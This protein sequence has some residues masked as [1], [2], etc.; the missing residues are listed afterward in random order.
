MHTGILYYCNIS[1]IWILY[2]IMSGTVMY[3]NVV[4]IPLILQTF[5][6]KPRGMVVD[7]DGDDDD[8]L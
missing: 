7:D 8:E 4:R 3:Q 1:D 2:D 6:N 5:S